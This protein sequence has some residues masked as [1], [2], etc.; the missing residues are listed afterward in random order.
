MLQIGFGL[1][2]GEAVQGA[3]GSHRKIDATY[4]SETVD[5]SETLESLT[6][7]Y[8]VKVL[9][10]GQFH[11]LLSNST[12]RKCRKVDQIL[13]DEID[14]EGVSGYDA[15]ELGNTME[16]FTYD[17]DVDVGQTEKLEMRKLATP[18]RQPSR[19]FDSKK[20]V[21]TV[22]AMWEDDCEA[23]VDD[24]KF[25]SRMK[26]KISRTTSGTFGSRSISGSRASRRSS[27][28]SL[29]LDSSFAHGKR[30]NEVSIVGG[31][32][33]EGTVGDTAEPSLPTMPSQLQSVSG[34][35][36]GSKVDSEITLPTG[37]AE[38]SSSVWVSEEMR[39]MRARY[40]DGMFFNS[41]DSGL[42]SY[43]AG[44][45]VDARQ[46][47]ATILERLK[48]GPSMY[49]MKLMEENNWKPPRNFSGYGYP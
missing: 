24:K 15:V 21:A 13:V 46:C 43:F 40:T 30:I 5:R 33:R 29:G 17:F 42:R 6:K 18:K 9:M 37:P 49:F 3:I 11:E 45:W 1:H 12:R 39:L 26:K 34:T 19:R 20:H 25:M 4:L 48:D 36:N 38:F 7:R 27:D 16:L 10:S 32:K 47:F 44:N 41:F 35:E 2:A 14:E 28:D 23:M 22:Q 8:G 31:F